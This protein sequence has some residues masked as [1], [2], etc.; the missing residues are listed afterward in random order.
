[1]PG[2]KVRRHFK[3][4]VKECLHQ[5]LKKF[6]YGTY[7]TLQKNTTLG[8][9]LKVIKSKDKNQSNVKNH[10]VESKKFKCALLT[11]DL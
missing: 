8:Q 6:S 1:M 7:F 2:T 9:K 10:K 5:S 3:G 4:L 11:F